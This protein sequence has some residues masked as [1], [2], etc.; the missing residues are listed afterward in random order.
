MDDLHIVSFSGG[1]D[2]TAML[3]MMIEKGMHIDEIINVDTTKEFPE[4]YSHIDKVKRYIFPKE[5]KILQFDFEYYL[6]HHIKTKGKNKG[7]AGYGWPDHMS[8]WCTALKRSLTNKYL[9]QK[10]KEG[11]KVIEYQGIAFDELKRTERNVDGRNIVYPLVD[12]KITEAEAL[13]YCYGKGFDWNNLY[14]VQSRV[15]CFLCPLQ[16]IGDLRHIYNERPELW[17]EIAELDKISF[18]RFRKEYTLDQLEV[19]FEKEKEIK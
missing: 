1:K 15:S 4:M 6:A 5:I 9:S 8:R 11:Y 10:K 7:K 17:A 13:E 16:R 3:L 18:R 14:E 12:W 19:K 2:S